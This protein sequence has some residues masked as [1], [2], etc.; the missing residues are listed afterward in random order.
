MG[1]IIGTDMEKALRGSLMKTVFLN[2]IIAIKPAFLRSIQY[3]NTT[4]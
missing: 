4:K 3:L 2:Y 1:K